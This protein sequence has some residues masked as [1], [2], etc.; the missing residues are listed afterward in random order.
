MMTRLA[1]LR[2]T[3]GGTQTKQTKESLPMSST[4]RKLVYDDDQ[5]DVS[6]ILKNTPSSKT[7]Q[8]TC[9]HGASLIDIKMTPAEDMVLLHRKKQEDKAPAYSFSFVAG[10]THDRIVSM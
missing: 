6:L 10:M 3:S 1:A 4:K 2:L 9:M 7:P 8:V 5:N